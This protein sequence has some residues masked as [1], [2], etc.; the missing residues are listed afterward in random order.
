MDQSILI[1]IKKL[2]GLAP[3]YTAFDSDVVVYINSVLMTLNQIGIGPDEGFI[4]TGPYELWTDF[5]P[6][7]I[8]DQQGIPTYIYL[9]V[10]LMFDP[11]ASSFGQEALKK[12]AEE[13]EWRLNV[14]SPEFEKES[15][16]S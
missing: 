2:L 10:K 14:Q 9:K 7:E 6:N 15:G 5:V 3:D 8:T 11:P 12:Q 1:T 13:I 16:I 4:I